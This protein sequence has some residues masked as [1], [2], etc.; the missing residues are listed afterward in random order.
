MQAGE[1]PAA[2][3]AP[4]SRA[5]SGLGL[6]LRIGSSHQISEAASQAKFFTGPA[7][8]TA[9]WTQGSLLHAL[10]GPTGTPCAGA[11]KGVRE[12]HPT[13]GLHITSSAQTPLSETSPGG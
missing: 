5:S 9:Q 4:A 6:L 3:P 10:A 12:G 2:L 8:Q 1:E 13:N 11:G 7:S